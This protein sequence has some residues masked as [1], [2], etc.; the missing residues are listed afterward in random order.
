MEKLVIMKDTKNLKPIILK[1]KEKDVYEITK[2]QLE[3]II[4]QAYDAGRMFCPPV[5][6]PPLTVPGNGSGDW[7]APYYPYKITCDA[8]SVSDYK[9]SFVKITFEGDINE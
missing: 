7:T 5:Y 1:Q 4:E 8:T 6:N 3:S 9:D 2:E